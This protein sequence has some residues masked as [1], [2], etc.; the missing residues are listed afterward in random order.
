[1]GQGTDSCGG[2]DDE[3]D[4]YDGENL[5]FG[6]WTAKDGE[7]HVS[8]MS[9]EHIKRARRKCIALSHTSSFTSE[10]EKWD[11]WVDAFDDELLRRERY[12][13]VSSKTKTKI[14]TNSKSDSKTPKS[15]GIR[16][17]MVCF[18][19]ITYEPRVSDL[20]RGWGLTCSKRCAAVK[21]E[22][23]RPMPIEAGTGRSVKDLL[24]HKNNDLKESAR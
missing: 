19:G 11:A 22:F 14:K 23:G 3:Y 7:I 24:G 20:K 5:S 17:S 4:E 16:V 13:A 10:S 18:C 6:V 9:E 21:R 1:M 12:G 8:Q 2:W 15:S